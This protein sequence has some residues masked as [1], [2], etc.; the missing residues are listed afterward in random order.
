MSKATEEETI[1]VEDAKAEAS[2]ARRSMA[3]KEGRS[4]FFII[5]CVLVFRSSFFEPFK[6][7]SGSM[8]PTLIIG[9]FILVNKTSYGFKVPFSQFF[10]DP[11]Y[12]T[13]PSHP[14]R[15]DVV[16]FK[17]PL[18][19][20]LNFIKRVV[21]LPGDSVEI[22]DKVLYVNDRP[23]ETVQVDGKAYMDDMDEK[24]KRFNFQFFKSKMGEREHIIQIDEDNDYA[25]HMPRKIIPKDQFFVMGDNRDNSHD[26]RYWGF[27]PFSKI[28]GRAFLVWFSA[29][30]VMPWS[31]ES[32]TYKFRPWRI[33]KSID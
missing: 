29:S 15:G 11:I 12:I 2:K 16:V 8:I 6:I 9:D 23:V 25:S 19:E 26:S 21:G 27:V 32:E 20:N 24:F 31:D 3:L 13:E 5:L 22:I 10:G 4:I 7:P 18:D 14:K 33:G 17:Y 1:I 30:L 28:K